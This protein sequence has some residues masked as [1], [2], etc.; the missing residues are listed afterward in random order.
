MRRHR[1]A[2]QLLTLLSIVGGAFVAYYGI[3]LSA[4]VRAASTTPGVS[5]IS[6]L[7]LATI[8]CLYAF[9]SVL[10][11]CGA[12]A[13]HERIRCL[14]VYFYATIFVSIILLLFTYTALAA[15]T[16]I[17]NWLRLHWSSLGLED[18]V[19]CKTFEDAQAYLSERFV[20]MGIIAGVSVVCM[21]IALY[22][23]VMI[24]TVPM[25]MRDILSVLN[26]M[27][28]FLSLGA[29]IYGTYMTYHNIMDAGQQWM[30]SIIITTGIL[31]LALSTIG[32]IGSKAKSRSVLLL[33]VVGIC[34]CIIILL[35]CAVFTI[36]YGGHLAE[37]YQSDKFP[38]DI[39][40][41]SG[42]YGCSNCTDFIPCKGAQKQSPTIDI[43]QP[44]NSSN[45]MPCFTNMTVL[46]VRNQTH[47]GSSPIY[48]QAAECSRC[49]EW[50]KTQ[51]ISYT[52]H[53]LDLLG[54]FAL[55]NSIFLFLALLSAIIMRRSLEGYQTESI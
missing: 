21:F 11:F 8:G 55:I 48:N 2:L 13:K 40:C 3:T 31:I 47:T 16:T 36:T 27:F 45:P 44:C 32:V 51:V 23:V 12:I 18:Q 28:I 30:A 20:Y 49:P 25:V 33:Y 22:C 35:F 43:W 7:A 46:F 9:A 50:S 29:I 10:G 34:L 5:S 26:A 54:I 38:G 39:A 14:M 15:P 4:M 19:C 24:V 37:A 41:E 17:S 6:A 53:M 52:T 1:H 42:L